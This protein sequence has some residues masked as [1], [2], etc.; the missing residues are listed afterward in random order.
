MNNWDI[1]HILSSPISYTQQDIMG[2]DNNIM[3]LWYFIIF[4]NYIKCF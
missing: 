4:S 1:L 2:F 3:I